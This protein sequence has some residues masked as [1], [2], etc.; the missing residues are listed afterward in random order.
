MSKIQVQEINPEQ[1]NRP[2]VDVFMH[3]AALGA[4]GLVSAVA[5]ASGAIEDSYRSAIESQANA[6]VRVAEFV[7][8]TLAALVLG[9]TVLVS[10]VKF[11]GAVTRL[12]SRNQP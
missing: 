7:P 12:R 2:G 9:A 8:P 10:A 4:A 3:G 6:A 5:V 11:A 1:S